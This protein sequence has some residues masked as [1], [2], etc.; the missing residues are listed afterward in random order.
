MAE[1]TRQ[2]TL[3]SFGVACERRTVLRTAALKMYDHNYIAV[4]RANA[5]GRAPIVI[6][7]A[8]GSWHRLAETF[9]FSNARAYIGTLF[10]ISTS[11]V[12]EVIGRLIE[13]EFQKPLPAALW[14]AQR[15]VYKGTPVAPM[16]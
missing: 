1:E 15:Q 16:L 14:A 7:N 2:G 4:P 13:K 11:E 6:N 12:Q 5:N 10:P 9:S 8:C 3:A